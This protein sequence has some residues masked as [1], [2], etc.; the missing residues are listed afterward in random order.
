MPST[1]Y[2]DTVLGKCFGLSVTFDLTTSALEPGYAGA[3]GLEEN[4]RKLVTTVS[5]LTVGC[6]RTY[7]LLYL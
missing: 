2:G 1:G 4:E 3:M 6:Y 5:Y 7:F